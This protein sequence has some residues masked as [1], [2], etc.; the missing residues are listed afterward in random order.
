VIDCDGRKFYSGFAGDLSPTSG[1]LAVVGRKK[2]L[3]TIPDWAANEAGVYIGDDAMKMRKFLKLTWPVEG[4]RFDDL[5]DYEKLI[6]GLLIELR[7]S[8]ETHPIMM[9]ET[10]N[11]T[12]QIREQITRRMFEVFNVPALCIVPRS[13][14]ALYANGRST[15]LVIDISETVC[16]IVPVYEGYRVPHAVVRCNF[17]MRSIVDC[18]CRQLLEY[19][20]AEQGGRAAWLEIVR[21][22]VED[23]AFVALDFAEA[24]TQASESTALCKEYELPDGQII[25]VNTPRFAAPEMLFTPE[26]DKEGTEEPG[27]HTA[28]LRA[29]NAC[30]VDIRRQLF[31]NIILT[32]P[33][34]MFKGIAERLTKEI[35]ALAPQTAV[36]VIA[37]NDRA[38]SPWVGAS[39]FAGLST[40]TI[41]RFF[42]TREEYD[43]YGP[44][45]V[46]SKFIC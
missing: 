8:P 36:R 27:I 14:M 22:I 20:I 1:M 44:N 39:T 3:Y 5:D 46:H 18:M 10:D 21:K 2:S 29:I 19:G 15:G 38:Y 16:Y 40:T 24:C 43:E 25:I 33:G 17:G 41:E 32:G 34:T 35:V 4:C 45:I 9:T 11:S 12:K 42:V 37:A 26:I 7:V 6:G 23:T 30:D 28:A 13:A 31:E